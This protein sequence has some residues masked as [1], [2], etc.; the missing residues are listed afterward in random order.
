ML[1]WITRLFGKK[2]TKAS[3]T[4]SDPRGVL[5][6]A[7]A[8]GNPINVVRVTKGS[9]VGQSTY[10]P[11]EM[12][13]QPAPHTTR[14][15]LSA[16]DWPTGVHRLSAEDFKKEH[17]MQPYQAVAIAALSSRERRGPRAENVA[18]VNRDVFGAKPVQRRPPVSEQRP[19]NT[20]AVWP[21]GQSEPVW[22][23]AG[24][25]GSYESKREAFSSGGG[26]DFGGGGA[27]SS[28]VAEAT[29]SSSSSD[30]GSSS[31]SDSSSSSSD[32][33]S[34]CSSSD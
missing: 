20:V 31:S 15:D 29:C 33:G 18:S 11:R 21:M 19:D 7:D 22:V 30:S 8:R 13:A 17:T 24:P 32:S 5:I 26:G 6:R 1:D 12:L 34:S 2:K 27:T 3:M 16:T 14:P 4:A 23:D 28:W 25:T 10:F 9:A